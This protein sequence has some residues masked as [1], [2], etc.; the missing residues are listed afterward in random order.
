MCCARDGGGAA[1]WADGTSG[2][3]V[4]A[5]LDITGEH[6]KL[7]GTMSRACES[8]SVFRVYNLQ[9]LLDCLLGDQ[10]LVP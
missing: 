4:T 2:N 6:G 8:P 3:V 10:E 7:S 1:R 9:S 5:E